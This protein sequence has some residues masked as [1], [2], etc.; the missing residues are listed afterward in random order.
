MSEWARPAGGPFEKKSMKLPSGPITYHIAGDGPPILYLH[1]AGGIRFTHA[2]DAL[3]EKF[4]I[5]MMVSPG[6]SYSKAPDQEHFLRQ[7][8]TN[9]LFR[10]ILSN[11]KRQWRFNQS[12]LFL[13]FLMGKKS[14]E[15]TP[16]G[17][18][19]YNIFGWQ[20][21]CYLLQEGYAST[22]KELLDTTEW[23]NYGK[24]SGN[25][26]CRDCMVHSGFEATAVDKTFTTWQGLKDTVI[27]KMSG[28]L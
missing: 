14:Y 6:Y 5:C 2:L 13:Q 15:C 10:E 16:W 28:T 8:R 4:R 9:E 22:F 3:S 19:T 26:K 21:P 24:S 27:A 25:P 12:P 18:P 7:N 1:S 17:N 23:D 11:N 20:R